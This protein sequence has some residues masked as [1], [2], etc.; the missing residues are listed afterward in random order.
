MALPTSQVTTRHNNSWGWFFGNG[1]TTNTINSISDRTNHYGNALQPVNRRN[2]GFYYI[3]I[4]LVSILIFMWV[5][6]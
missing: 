5:D 1:F 4:V 3:K 2:S 6:H